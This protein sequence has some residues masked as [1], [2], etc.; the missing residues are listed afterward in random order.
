MTCSN[1]VKADPDYD[2]DYG[3]DWSSWLATNDIIVDSEWI[4]PAELTNHDSGHGDD[5]AVIWLSGGESVNVYEVTNRIT[6][7]AGRQ[8]DQTIYYRVED[9]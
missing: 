3:I 1:R 4:V 5:L 6:T 7:L 9:N 8:K 2:L